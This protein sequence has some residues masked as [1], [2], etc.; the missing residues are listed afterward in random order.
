MA[1]HA[2]AIHSEAKGAKVD[3]AV[4]L[5]ILQ[6][7]DNMLDLKEK[8]K[9]GVAIG[10]G[11]RSGTLPDRAASLTEL[12]NMFTT[13][14]LSVLKARAELLRVKTVLCDVII[15]KSSP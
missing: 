6:R 13:M 7:I 5:S 4:M 3:A 2:K 11:T 1:E 12:L 14:S 15:G 9:S 10:L 8:M